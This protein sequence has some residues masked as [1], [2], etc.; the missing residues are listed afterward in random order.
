[1]K[2]HTRSLIL[3]VLLGYFFLMVGNGSISLTHPDEVFYMQTAKEM[4]HRH[5]W[6]TPI[7]FDEPQ[8]EK[9]F[10]SYDF[11]RLARE[12]FGD[13]DAGARFFPALFGIIGL[14]L[15][16]AIAWMLFQSKRLAFLSGFI[17]GT[18]FI[19]IA[20][21]RA[22][23]TDMIFSVMILASVTGFCMA[24]V[25]P[26]RKT[27][28]ILLGFT[29]SALAVLIK[30]LLGFVFPVTTVL[31]FLVFKRDQ[32]FVKTWAV[33]AGLLLF[34]ALALPWHVVMYKLYGNNFLHEYFSNV[35]LRRLYTA[36]HER[37][38]HWYFYPGLMFAGMLPWSLF[39]IP[40]F[41][42]L[43]RM[44]HKKEKR[45][46]NVEFLL[47]WI[48]A[49]LLYTQSATSKLASYIF[50]LYPAIA[51]L[52]A[53]YI[54][55]KWQQVEKGGKGL[56]FSRIGYIMILLLVVGS[57]A[58][59]FVAQDHLSLLKSMKLIYITVAVAWVVALMLLYFN[60]V[61]QYV[62]MTFALGGISVVLLFLLYFAVPYIEP[63]VSCRQVTDLL[64]TVDQSDTPVLAS[65]FYVRGVRYYTDRPVAVIDINGKGFWSPHPI[66][67]L[68][69]DDMVVNFFKSRP[70]TYAI[71]KEGDVMNIKRVLRRL[72][73]KI[74]EQGEVGG[75]FILKVSRL[76]Q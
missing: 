43:Y 51:I 67:F 56:S 18:T 76:K 29:F 30:G 26:S 75:K 41:G 17:L 57:I 61:R 52:F 13:N 55:E 45:R 49:V 36:E 66:P 44:F 5:T 58:G 6:F 34:L 14:L 73:F 65:K 8:F 59:I 46:L 28:G 47:A 22:V 62:K 72:P 54:D 69:R 39:W 23:L 63:W 3:L 4:Q 32:T 15:V 68:N 50:P 64:K 2:S 35:H 21:S 24:Y 1:M 33:P 70:V 53:Q 74:K 7:L 16:Y 12:L 25:Y 60:I 27:A 38:N 9:P 31:F 40:I 37:L 42:Q 48:F 71:V 19:Y 10:L 11:F 20:L